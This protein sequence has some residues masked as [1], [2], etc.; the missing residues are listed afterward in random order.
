MI[1]YIRINR[2]STSSWMTLQLPWPMTLEDAEKWCQ[3]NMVGWEVFSG[4]YTNPD[5]T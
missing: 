2:S 4:C 3:W 1:K 5:E